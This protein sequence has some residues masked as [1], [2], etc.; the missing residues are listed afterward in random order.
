M[1]KS[2]DRLFLA[3][4]PN[5]EIHETDAYMGEPGEL[6]YSAE[7]VRRAL[8]EARAEER[9]AIMSYVNSL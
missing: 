6:Y 4:S 8:E 9:D 7:Y 3:F 1:S 5:G 2:P